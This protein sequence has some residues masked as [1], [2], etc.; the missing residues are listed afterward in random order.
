MFIIRDREAGNYISQ[1]NTYE[2]AMKA[3]NMYEADDKNDGVY[4]PDFYEIILENYM[5]L[6]TG[7]EFTLE[8]LRHE[9]DLYKA[10]MPY[11]NFEDYLEK[12]LELGRNKEGGLIKL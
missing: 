2:E 11:E 7:E 1:H 5:N 12:M 3:Y 4:T 10:D 6:D 8:E 9:Y